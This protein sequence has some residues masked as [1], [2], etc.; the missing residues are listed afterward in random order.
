MQTTVTMRIMDG[1]APRPMMSSSTCTI[2]PPARATSACD[3]TFHQLTFKLAFF[4]SRHSVCE[5]CVR[6]RAAVRKIPAF[7]NHG[8]SRSA[9]SHVP[10][11]LSRGTQTASLSPLTV[12]GYRTTTDT[13]HQ[14]NVST[15]AES[16]KP[17]FECKLKLKPQSIITCR[18]HRVDYQ[19]PVLC[20]QLGRQLIQVSAGLHIPTTLTQLYDL[21]ICLEFGASPVCCQAWPI[22][23]LSNDLLLRQTVTMRKKMCL[24]CPVQLICNCRAS[25]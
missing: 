9:M 3:V 13:G 7:G 4:W 10:K 18:Q 25:I 19:Y 12:S 23:S 1:D 14:Q 5:K 24:C 8:E 15:N 20:I 16:L 21:P 2:V 11:S 6:D 22:C 17:D